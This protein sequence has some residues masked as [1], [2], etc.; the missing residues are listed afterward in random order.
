MDGQQG[1]L[2]LALLTAASAVLAVANE[3]SHGL[4]FDEVLVQVQL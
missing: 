4:G 3:R 2:Y 1:R